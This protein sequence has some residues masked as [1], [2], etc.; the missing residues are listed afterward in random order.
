MELKE[1]P[2]SMPQFTE[3]DVQELKRAA[4]ISLLGFIATKLLITYIIHKA[5][6]S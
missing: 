1:Y 3:Y 2:S 5:A 4:I 6:R